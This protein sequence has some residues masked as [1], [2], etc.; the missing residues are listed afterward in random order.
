[1]TG[2]TITCSPPGTGGY[3]DPAGDNLTLNVQTG[4]TVVD[5]GFAAIELR[6]FNT[7]T[8]N[9]TISAGD[10]AAGIYVDDDNTI[11][12]NGTITAGADGVGISADDRN[13][14]TNAGS[15]TVGDGFG[16]YGIAVGFDST[17]FNSGT[18]TVGEG[19][20]GIAA[21]ANTALPATDSVTNSG[22]I[23]VGDFGAGIYVI[24]N[25]RVLNSGTITGGQSA[26]GIRTDSN[27]VITNTGTI[28][29]GAS[30]TGVEF[31]LDN[32][33][34]YNYGTIKATGGGFSVTS[35]NCT[36]GNAFN[37]MS[38]GTLDGY[39]NVD[40]VGNTLTNSGLVTIT[41]PATALIGYPTFLFANTSTA[42]AGNSFVQ[43]ASGTLALRMDNAGT[44]D[45]LSAD[46]ITARGTLKVVIQPQLYQN[47]TFSGT[48]V[49]LTPYGAGTLGNTI[50][51]GFDKYTASSPFF[52]VTP[53]YDTGDASSYESLSIQLDR[54][55][56]GRVPGMTPNQAAVGNALEAGYS[57]TLTGS[58][59]TF[60]A[61]LFAASSGAVFDQLSG[62]GTSAAQDASFSAGALFGNAMF[63]QGLAWLTGSGGAANGISLGY[64]QEPRSR[65]AGHD[66][67]AAMRPR[68]AEPARWRA[69]ALG[70]GGMGNI[71]GESSTGSADQTT[72]TYGG[73]FGVDRQLADD[74]LI[75]VAAGGTGSH[76]SVSS[77]STS[78]DV[79]GGHVGVYAIKAFGPSYLA[80]TVSYARLDNRTERTITGVG[81]TET[82]TGRFDSDQ[83]SG[84]LEFGR[85]YGY[86]T[87]TL[88]PFMA[89]EPA[90]VWQKAYS[91]TSTVTGGGSGTLGLSY[92][93]N[94]VTSLPLFV[95]AQID[96]RR[97][98]SN[99][100]VFSPSL[101]AAWVH[102]FKPDR[103]IEASFVSVPS[104]SFTVDGARAARDAL[105]VEA[106]GT[107]ALNRSTA[108][109]AKL[110]GE[111]ASR[112]RMASATGGAK[113]TW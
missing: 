21:G 79:N 90:V 6:D 48:A 19:A 65:L 22:T 100:A 16:G 111:L 97:A 86:A 36:T 63:Q 9:G 46:A 30:G 98:L 83:L 76:F 49:G 85:R 39:I 42:G 74:L 28:T 101:R 82:A 77:L 17:V 7:I 92:A 10:N 87:Y 99:G 31:G 106:G 59:A 4:T 15:I 58:L 80:A 34:L 112:S 1:M 105:R 67:F 44:I 12:N 26:Y 94:T 13:S 47:T 5:N 68:A 72:R 8:N 64:A 52:T 89:I 84:R 113:L 110:D 24:E 109:F 2:S 108:L 73:A 104:P 61:N 3:S 27:N 95:G 91:E 71:D 20:T 78:G 62:Q 55:P 107:L 14:I 23:T 56:F 50:T 60:Y 45:N 11:R 96:T 35:C 33:T 57:P 54:I 103:T 102:E 18:I 40:G 37:N 51:S 81:P 29:V 69:W 66:A 93:A 75:G 70:F 43:T 41:D 25:H 53:I 38:G 88:T 32:N